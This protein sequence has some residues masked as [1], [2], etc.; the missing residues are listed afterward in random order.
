M[1]RAVPPDLHASLPGTAGLRRHTQGPLRR[2]RAADRDERRDHSRYR[3]IR[4][5]SRSAQEAEAT[6]VSHL[7]RKGTSASQSRLLVFREGLV[8][9]VPGDNHLAYE[10]EVG[11][12]AVREFVYVDAHGKVVDQITGTP[13]GM[14]RRAY[15]GSSSPAPPGYPDSP[16]WVEGDPF[17]TGTPRPTT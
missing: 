13:D 4:D 10:V 8:K 6:A 14:F 3:R 5:P 2:Q 12:G 9:G 7:K 15:D 11:N 17:P 1:P 16:F